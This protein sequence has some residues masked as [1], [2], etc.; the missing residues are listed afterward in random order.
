MVVLWGEPSEKCLSTL[1]CPVLSYAQL[2][3]RADLQSFTPAPIGPDTLATLVYT[4]GTTGTPKVLTFK[5]YRTWLLVHGMTEDIP[6]GRKLQI[7]GHVL[8]MQLL[9]VPLCLMNML[10]LGG[11]VDPR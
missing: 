1:D 10:A 7:Y 4:S 11:G 9:Y 2:M 3:A 5:T 8:G 6:V